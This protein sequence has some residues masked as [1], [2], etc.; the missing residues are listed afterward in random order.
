MEELA[1]PKMAE[2]LTENGLQICLKTLMD[3]LEQRMETFG[4][5]S[6]GAVVLKEL[7]RLHKNY[8]GKELWAVRLRGGVYMVD[9]DDIIMFN[10]NWYSAT[11]FD[12]KKTAFNFK[13]RIEK[14]YQKR[15]N[16][17]DFIVVRR[18]CRNF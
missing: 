13:K 16:E 3:A 5:N 7:K 11:W 10:I 2:L 12:D 14:L 9:C 1:Y 17:Y 6:E 8:S 4:Y 18:K 15:F